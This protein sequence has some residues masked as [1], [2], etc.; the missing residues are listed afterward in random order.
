[1]VSP[2]PIPQIRAR[3]DSAAER[4]AM[5]R[6]PPLKLHESNLR[7]MKAPV[8]LDEPD[9]RSLEVTPM[10][11]RLHT[12]QPDAD[13][14]DS[15]TGEIPITLAPSLN[16]SPPRPLRNY[17]QLDSNSSDSEDISPITA[18]PRPSVSSEMRL[19]RFFPELSSHFQVVAPLDRDGSMKKPVTPTL[20]GRNLEERAQNFYKQSIDASRAEK[21]RE[22][23]RNLTLDVQGALESKANHSSSGSE[24]VHDDGSSC[25]SRDSSSATSVDTEYEHHDDRKQL[26]PLKSADAYSIISPVAAGVFDDAASLP[27]RA[28]SA[29]PMYP[30]HVPIDMAC[31]P[32]HNSVTTTKMTMDHLKNK[33]LPLEPLMETSPAFNSL[34]PSQYTGSHRS[35]STRSP[36]VYQKDT[37]LSPVPRHANSTRHHR[38]HR[39]EDSAPTTP[40]ASRSQREHRSGSNH[41]TRKGSNETSRKGSSQQRMRHVPTLSRATEEL[42]DTLV[43][44]SRDRNTPQRTLLILDGPLQI[45]RNNGGDLVA[46]RPAPL[47]PHSAKAHSASKRPKIDRSFSHEASRMPKKEKP[48]KSTKRGSDELG[49]SETSRR[50]EIQKRDS[51]EKTEE[52]AKEKAKVQKSFTL[53]LPSF[54]RKPS[55]MQAADLRRISLS[56][57]SETSLAPPEE[58]DVDAMIALRGRQLSASHSDPNLNETA[59]QVDLRMQ[60]PRLQV[61]DL[62]FKNPFDDDSQQSKEIPRSH[63]SGSDSDESVDPIDSDHVLQLETPMSEHVLHLETPSEDE[64]IIVSC[65]KMRQSHALVSTFQASSV[66]FPEQV[67]ELAACPPSPTVEVYE[68]PEEEA[69]IHLVFPVKM[70]ETAL[71]AIM[72][73]I[74]SLDDLFNFAIVNRRFYEVFKQ[75]ELAMIKNTLFKMSPPAWELREMSPPWD[76]EWQLLLDLDSQVPEYT[77]SLY[78]RKYAQDIYTLAQLKSLVLERCSPFLRHD[79][80]RGL[81]GADVVRAE[82]VDDA[83]WRI[84]T[85]CRIFGSG[86]NRE[87]DI[88]AQ[89]DWLKGGQTAKRLDSTSSMAEPFGMNNVLFEPPQGFGRGNIGGLSQRQMYDMTEIWTCLGVLLQPLHGKCIEARKFGIFDNMDVSEGDTVKEETVLEEWTAYITTLGL[90]AV[91]TLGSLCLADS[92]AATFKKAQTI[93]LTKWEATDTNTSRSSFLKEAV[94]R[95]YENTDRGA[96]VQSPTD[97]AAKRTSS[98]SSQDSNTN[99]ENRER[100]AAFAIELRIR[101]M[102]GQDIQPDHNRS[103]SDERPMSVYSTVLNDLNGTTDRD[104]PPVPSVPA[105]VVDRFSNTSHGTSSTPGPQTPNPQTPPPMHTPPMHTPP[106]QSPQSFRCPTPTASLAPAPLRPQ[107]QVMDPVDRAINMIVNELGFAQEDAKWALKI[108]DTGEGIDVPAAV[109]MLQRQKKKHDR[110]N[111]FSNRK[112]SSLLTDVMKR[113]GSTDSGWRWA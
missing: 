62:G 110:N 95:A 11:S 63:H 97:L 91:L 50:S 80:V 46:T 58:A 23:A 21:R 98:L 39:L 94:S 79:T 2:L 36:S 75:R 33:P 20:T 31:P 89:M 15:D 103:F 104:A 22:A 107:P 100:Q 77:P 53:K 105:L 102:R 43:G 96:S 27:P 5:R 82:E 101:R 85:F 67:Y 47:P 4:K 65:D 83:F 35:P 99:R 12:S 9:I 1:M 78:L 93:G 57:R 108:T 88:V 109:H 51:K 19:A 52:K 64:K 18:Q 38:H 8:Q 87:T 56:S 41:S 48:S 60:L 26:R 16:I 76:T 111:L 72:Q 3:K 24:E 49:T 66:H 106:M 55:Q 25:Y 13:E 28:N 86:K 10:P 81:A 6:P 113:Q 71:V 90:S 7:N 61:N 54:S 42:E 34:S 84:W 68:L 70:P 44:M 112:R 69:P 92:N 74:D 17:S 32:R 30:P 37:Y 59:N 40:R 29:T 45:S 73:S 14:S